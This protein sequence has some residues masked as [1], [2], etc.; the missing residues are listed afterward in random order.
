MT[1]LFK[2][3]RISCSCSLF[4]LGGFGLQIQGSLLESLDSLLLLEDSDLLL[5][6]VH[7][8]LSYIRL[9]V[10]LLSIEQLQLTLKFLFMWRYEVL[11]L[12]G[13]SCVLFVIVAISLLVEE[14]EVPDHLSLLVRHM[15]SLE[16]TV[17]FLL[18]GIQ[19]LLVHDSRCQKFCLLRDF[20]FQVVHSLSVNL[21]LW[22]SV[23]EL[24]SLRSGVLGGLT[25]LTHVEPVLFLLLLDQLVLLLPLS[26]RKFRI[27]GGFVILTRRWLE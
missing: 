8:V 20:K 5:W 21:Q 7:V 18:L 1:P 10:L 25:I 26:H 27:L 22:L 13:F 9:E 3:K 24:D 2:S 11:V 17:L 19:S 12:D 16:W 6:L 23:D 4:G 15:C 14:L